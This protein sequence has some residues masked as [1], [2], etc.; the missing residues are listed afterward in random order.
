M[1]QIIA[2]HLKFHNVFQ[3]FNSFSYLK[4]LGFCKANS[5]LFAA[6][7]RQDGFQLFAALVGQ[8]FRVF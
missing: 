3:Q 6:Q 2:A 7:L 1:V 8:P 4:I 5:L